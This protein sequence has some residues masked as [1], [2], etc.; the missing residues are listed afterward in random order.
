MCPSQRDSIINFRA[1]GSEVPHTHT[2]WTLSLI[3]TSFVDCSGT[4]GDSVQSMSHDWRL[5]IR[6]WC[7]NAQHVKYASWNC[8]LDNA[9]GHTLYPDIKQVRISK[10]LTRTLAASLRISVSSLQSF[11]NPRWKNCGRVYRRRNLLYHICS[12]GC[13]FASFSQLHRNQFVLVCVI[14]CIFCS[15]TVLASRSCHRYCPSPG[16]KLSHARWNGSWSWEFQC[17][18]AWQWHALFCTDIKSSQWL[19]FAVIIIRSKTVPCWN[20]D[21]PCIVKTTTRNYYPIAEGVGWNEKTQL[22]NN[23]SLTYPAKTESCM[24][25]GAEMAPHY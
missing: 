24:D 6:T 10:L 11:I 9:E 7:R 2:N 25:L 16:G 18:L 15:V 4:C 21:L 1:T 17:G 22:P 8:W 3:F 23:L 13:K 19:N 5:A 14:K 20:A 12:L